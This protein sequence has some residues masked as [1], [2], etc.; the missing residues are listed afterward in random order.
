MTTKFLGST[1]TGSLT[2][3]STNIVGASLSGA[4]LLP[5]KAVKTSSASVLISTNLEISDTNGLQAAIDGAGV[6]SR[7]VNDISPADANGVLNIDTIKE[8]TLNNGIDIEDLNIKDNVLLNSNLDLTIQVPSGRDIVF[9]DGTEFARFHPNPPFS[10]LEVTSIIGSTQPNGILFL[11]STTDSIKGNIAIEGDQVQLFGDFLLGSSVPVNDILDEDNMVS[12]S[13]TALVSQQSVKAYVDAGDVFTT[14]G[15]TSSVDNGIT[16]KSDATNDGD[17]ILD[18]KANVIFKIDGT[19]GVNFDGTLMDLLGNLTVGANTGDSELNLGGP[20][21]STFNMASDTVKSCAINLDAGNSANITLNR[22]AT[23]DNAALFLET[24]GVVKIVA[25]LRNDSSENYTFTTGSSTVVMRLLHS[26]NTIEFPTSDTNVVTGNALLI[27]S[28]GEIGVVSS[29]IKS[30]MDIVQLNDSD[31][32]FIY[33]L[34]CRKFH[35]RNKDNS[36]EYTNDNNGELYF[37]CIAEELEPLA[38]AFCRYDHITDHVEGC[39][40]N[41]LSESACQ[42]ENIDCKCGVKKVLS[43]IHYDRMI[44]PLIQCIQQQ[45]VLIDSLQLRVSALETNH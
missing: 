24:N 10:S 43:G 26:N 3:G 33:N 4:N 40:C 20:G 5:A 38:S 7:S 25:G 1:A 6:F 34:N 14:S 45:K 16:I 32:E 8:E 15:I 44:T 35:Y 23:S 12:N 19:V 42:C 22:G 18:A 11:R 30:K 13:A 17:I 37:G 36:G 29:T 39:E 9:S 31:V 27:S 28:T 41:H 2:D 21:A